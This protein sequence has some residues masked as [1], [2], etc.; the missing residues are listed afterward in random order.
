[1]TKRIFI[2]TG[3]PLDDPELAAKFRALL[4]AGAKPFECV[5]EVNECRAAVLLSAR[6]DDRAESRLLQELAAEVASW[7]DAPSDADA[8][9]MLQP[10]GDN[11]IP[12]G[13]R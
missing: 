9:A 1:M 12:A 4:G 5:G 10:V 11:F 3:E 2:K 6:R 7:P 13:Y 8:A